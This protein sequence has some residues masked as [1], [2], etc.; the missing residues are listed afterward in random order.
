MRCSKDPNTARH[1]FMRKMKENGPT[2]RASATIEIVTIY[3]SPCLII[4]LCFLGSNAPCL[5]VLADW[6]LPDP[7]LAIAYKPAGRVRSN[8]KVKYLTMYRSNLLPNLCYREQ[9]SWENFLLGEWCMPVAQYRMRLGK[10]KDVE[11]REI[12]NG[13]YVYFRWSQ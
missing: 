1:L 3:I 7:M 8:Y 12:G 4:V 5:L 9:A 13:T 6:S 2:K 10:G 11:S